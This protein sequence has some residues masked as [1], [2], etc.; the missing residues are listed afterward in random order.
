[1]CTTPSNKENHMATECGYPRESIE[2]SAR[3]FTLAGT[4]GPTAKAIG[5]V[6]SVVT[7]RKSLTGS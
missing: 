5:T 7:G 1:M 2:L 3:V 4:S 6:A